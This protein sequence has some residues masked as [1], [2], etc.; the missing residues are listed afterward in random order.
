MIV[1]LCLDC[2]HATRFPLEDHSPGILAQLQGF[3]LTPSHSDYVASVFLCEGCH[4]YTY[5]PQ[6]YAHADYTGPH[7][8]EHAPGRIKPRRLRYRR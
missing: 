6:N 2:L 3:T 5:E 1:S 4:T 7:L 8:C